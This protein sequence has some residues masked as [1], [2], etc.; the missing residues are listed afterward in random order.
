MNLK[1]E[2]YVALIVFFG[3]FLQKILSGKLE[4]IHYYTLTIASYAL[5]D[6][7]KGKK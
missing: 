4:P 2:I 1:R 3:L 5:Y 6:S 7:Q